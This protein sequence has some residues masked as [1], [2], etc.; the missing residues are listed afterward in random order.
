MVRRLGLGEKQPSDL[1]QSCAQPSIYIM[2]E[3]C[4]TCIKAPLKNVAEYIHGESICFELIRLDISGELHEMS[5]QIF[6]AK[7]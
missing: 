4:Q 7:L 2:S 5:S 3:Y 6:S 1:C